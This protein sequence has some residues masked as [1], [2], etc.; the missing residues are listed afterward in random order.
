[1]GRRGSSGKLPRWYKGRLRLESRS[2]FWYGEREGKLFM[3]EGK[4]VD[5]A[6]LDTL[7]DIQREEQ[8]KRIIQRR[9]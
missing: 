4:L 7:T 9:E 5:K 1:M 3:Q 6:N 8:V 2:G